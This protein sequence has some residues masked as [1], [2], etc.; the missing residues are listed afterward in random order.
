MHTLHLTGSCQFSPQLKLVVKNRKQSFVNMIRSRAEGVFGNYTCT[1][2]RAVLSKV[3]G[4]GGSEIW[5]DLQGTHQNCRPHEQRTGLASGYWTLTTWW[6]S[7]AGHH[8]NSRLH[9][10]GGRGKRLYVE[11]RLNMNKQ[12]ADKLESNAMSHLKKKT[13][14]MWRHIL[15]AISYMSSMLWMHTVASEYY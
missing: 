10:R 9:W 11:W 13:T 7:G 6:Q 4:G 8:F 14:H 5:M 15:S 3:G 12:R 2:I 1:D